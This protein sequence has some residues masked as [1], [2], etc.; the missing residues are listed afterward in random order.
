MNSYFVVLSNLSVIPCVIHYIHHKKYIYALQIGLNSLFSLIHHML[1]SK[2]LIWDNTDDLFLFIDAFYSYLSI[3]V[4]TI[5]FFLSLNPNDI[6][7]ESSIFQAVLLP[8]I[9]INIE[10]YI[11]IS[12]ITAYILLIVGLHLH[13]IRPIFLCNPYVYLVFIMCITDISCY[14]IATYSDY[15]LFHSLHHLV[16]F[17]LP[18]YVNKCIQWQPLELDGL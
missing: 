6:L 3:Y 7:L 18:M 2:L 9:F 14:I 13:S 8:I 17:T 10:F 12:I 16:A 5:Y 11:V 1:S 4:F 15:Y